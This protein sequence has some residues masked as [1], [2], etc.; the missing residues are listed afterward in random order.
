M[1]PVLMPIDGAE[2]AFES[3]SVNVGGISH[4]GGHK[5]AGNVIIYVP[6]KYELVDHDLPIVSPLAGSGIWY[7]RVE[8]KHVD[9][10]IKETILGGRIIQEL[11]RGGVDQQGNP[12]RI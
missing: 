9:G 12:V 8:P 7:G 10:I 4:V 2:N 1:L 5:W 11:F 3:R 6:P